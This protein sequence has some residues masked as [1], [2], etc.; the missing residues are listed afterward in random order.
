MKPSHLIKLVFGLCVVLNMVAA[1][2]N[3]NRW[4]T[5]SK[6]QHTVNRTYQLVYGSVDMCQRYSPKEAKAVLAESKRFKHTYPNFIRALEKSPYFS[7]AKKSMDE[8]INE[9]A[10]NAMKDPKLASCQEAISMM[11][12]VIEDPDGKQ[13]IDEMLL[14]IQ[15]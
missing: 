11:K 4:A 8:S 10:P 3:S 5:N 9:M 15:K 14:D 2:A 7:Q 12:Q 13:F 1:S 6:A